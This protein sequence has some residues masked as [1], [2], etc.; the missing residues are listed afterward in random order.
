MTRRDRFNTIIE[1]LAAMF[2][3]AFILIIVGLMVGAIV[4]W[5][6]VV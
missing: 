6:T 1:S 3:L 2:Q 4:S 5:G